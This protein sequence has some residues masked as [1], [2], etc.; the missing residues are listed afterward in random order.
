MEE[1]SKKQLRRRR[2]REAVLEARKE[3]RKEKKHAPKPKTPYRTNRAAWD[4]AR[5]TGLRIVIDCEWEPDMTDRELSSLKQQLKFCHGLNAR[6]VKPCRLTFSG[7][8]DKLHAGLLKVDAV[9]WPVT[10]E[11]RPYTELFAREELVYLTADSSTTIEALDPDKVYIIGGLVDHNR[12]KF[13]S[14]Q[15]AVGQQIATARLPI[16]AHCE[17]QTSRVLA[18][19]HILNILLLYWESCDWAETFMEVIPGRKK[20]KLKEEEEEKRE[21]EEEHKADSPTA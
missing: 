19:N 6:S 10:M 11:R 18:V 13:A 15:K 20:A 16:E 1:L 4:E 8:G 7:L 21:E 14:L 17:M 12:L 9:N 2:R 5:A 3:K